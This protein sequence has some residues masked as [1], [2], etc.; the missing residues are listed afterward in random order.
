ME[1][2]VAV[3]ILLYHLQYFTL[4]TCNGIFDLEKMSLKHGKC[5]CIVDHGSFTC[6]SGTG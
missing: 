4:I 3:C 5:L 2:L 1:K 6:V